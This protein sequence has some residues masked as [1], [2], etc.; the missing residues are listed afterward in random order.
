MIAPDE[1]ESDKSTERKRWELANTSCT[2]TMEFQLLVLVARATNG[3]PELRL[4]F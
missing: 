4:S 2:T 3:I 1:N